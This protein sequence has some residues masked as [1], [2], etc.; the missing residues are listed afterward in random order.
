MGRITSRTN[1]KSPRCR[2]AGKKKIGQPIAS[3]KNRPPLKKEKNHDHVCGQ[4]VYAHFTILVFSV[5]F[6]K[7]KGASPPFPG[8]ALAAK[9]YIYLGCNSAIGMVKK[10]GSSPD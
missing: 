5:K 7:K 9:S 2:Q 1:T 4:E 8:N 3:H 10:I 6:F